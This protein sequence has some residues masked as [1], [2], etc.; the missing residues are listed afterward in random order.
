MHKPIYKCNIKIIE[1]NSELFYYAINLIRSAKKY[2]NIQCFI[3]NFNGFWT[4]FIF[5]EL[6][7]KANEGVKI[8]LIYDWVGAY[9]RVKP[10]IFNELQKYGIEVACF[11]PKGITKFKG[12]TNYRLHSKFIIIDNEIAMYGGSNFSDEYLSMSF[13]EPHWRDLNFIIQ[14]PILTTIN[15]TF[16]NYWINFTKKNNN[17]Y[18]CQNI[19]NDLSLILPKKDLKYTNSLTQ[20]LVFDPNYN[21]FILEKVFCNLIYNAKKSIKI[22][23]PYFCMPSS[24]INALKYCKNKNI[25]IQLIAHNKNQRYVQMINRDNYSKLINWGIKVYEY[26]GY[27]HS[28]CI[29]IDDEYALVGSCNFD[30][31]SIYMNFE[32]AIIVDSTQ[33]ISSLIKNFDNTKKNSLLLTSSFINKKLNLWTKFVLKLLNVGK[34]LF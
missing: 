28:K 12:A 5:T 29:I 16:I 33:I 3:Y 19:L 4:R 17:K 2:I 10:S 23:T 15:I 21:E 14:G 34:N 26:D 25:D 20:L 32:S 8:R 13:N 9:K 22:L 24:F 31:R 1:D 6:I 18:S 27:L 7:K 30:Y 11:N